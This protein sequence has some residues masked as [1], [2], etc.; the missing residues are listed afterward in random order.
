MHIGFA[1][2]DF[3][4]V[5]VAGHCFIDVSYNRMMKNL[6]VLLFSVCV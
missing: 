1:I 3:V 6:K 2:H 5:Y 4:S